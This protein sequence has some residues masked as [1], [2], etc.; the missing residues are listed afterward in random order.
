M[1]CV[2]A[3][4]SHKID[5]NSQ[6]K[7]IR[8]KLQTNRQTANKGRKPIYLFLAA[9]LIVASAF[10]A[11][12]ILYNSEDP[13]SSSQIATSTNTH[14]SAPESTSITVI[15][16]LENTVTITL[17]VTRIVSINYGLTEIICA[18]GGQD[19]LVGRDELS[20]SPPSVTSVP[21][22]ASTSNDPNM[23]L[24]LESKPDLILVDS[25]FRSK[26]HEIALIKDAGI[27]L[28]I[29]STGNFSR[30]LECINNMGRILNKEQTANDLR[31]FLTHYQTLVADRVANLSPS[32]QPRVYLEWTSSWYTATHPSV[33]SVLTA[34]GGINIAEGGLASSMG[35]ISPEFV[36][37]ANPEVILKVVSGTN[38]GVES[39]KVQYDDLLGRSLLSDTDAIKNQRVYT[40]YNIITQGIRYPIGL[41]Y[42]EKWLYPDL[43]SDIDPAAVQDELYQRFFGI[44]LEGVYTYP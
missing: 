26:T 17:P 3:I 44:T 27:P 14:P 19:L 32:Q 37:E 41:L 35:D 11:Y 13:S 25:M 38:Y 20:T 34:A 29:E 22:V 42:Y 4:P 18:I 33:A 12:S 2:N 24:L 30:I 15:D 9:I 8:A 6:T 40:Y 10:V 31:N 43:L 16:G 36:M 7:Q 28:Y 21:T 39:L 1:N 23:E 5:V